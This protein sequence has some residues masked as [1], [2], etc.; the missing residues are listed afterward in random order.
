MSSS[1]AQPS[2]VYYLPARA[3]VAEPD[4]WPDLPTRLQHAW[5]RF[6]LALAEVRAL[7]R[8]RPRPAGPLPAGEDAPTR[9]VR[10]AE[11][12]DF[13]DARRRLRP[14]PQD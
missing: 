1:E 11:V 13:Q 3:F 9:P 14:A 10:P 7:L 2:N 5:W 4:P 8:S 12:I 6:R